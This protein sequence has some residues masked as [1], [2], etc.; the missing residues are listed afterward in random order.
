M[1]I[2]KVKIQVSTTDEI[3]RPKKKPVTLGNKLNLNL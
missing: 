3:L 1:F 2:Q